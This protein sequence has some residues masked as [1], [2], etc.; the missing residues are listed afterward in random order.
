MSFMNFFSG[1]AAPTADL[2]TAQP[3]QP[4]APAQQQPTTPTPG[5]EP[6]GQQAQQQGAPGNE[7]QPTPPNPLDIYGKMFETTK[8]DG[9]TPSAPSL[10]LDSKV[11]SEVTNQL[12]FTKG[13]DPEMLQKLQSGDL[14]SLPDMLNAVARQAYSTAMQHN[15]AL[16]D[17]FVSQRSDYDAQRIA[18]TVRD[19]LTQSKLSTSVE[20]L[21]FPGM[22][23]QLTDVASKLAKAYPDATPDW[24]AEQAQA[25]MRESAARVMGLTPEMIAQLQSMQQQQTT[26][27]ASE[28]EWDK[29]FDKE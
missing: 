13:I 17:K 25:Y 3:A 21:D 16:V 14:S 18:P 4:A 15:S 7:G 19:A 29:Y 26:K 11:L 27:K 20:G 12:D 6:A 9:D 1:N 28:V 8:D 22:K 23:Q 5:Q 2:G 10:S 24:V